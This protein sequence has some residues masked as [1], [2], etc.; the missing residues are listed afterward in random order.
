MLLGVFKLSLNIISHVCVLARVRVSACACVCACM[1]MLEYSPV[2]QTNLMLIELCMQLF[3]DAGQYVIRFGHADPLAK[4][5]PASAVSS[6]LIVLIVFTPII[7]LTTLLYV[8]ISDSR[9]G[10]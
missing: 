4:T 5:G 3:T 7:L 6:I 8:S 9:I 2:Y 1:C 10:N